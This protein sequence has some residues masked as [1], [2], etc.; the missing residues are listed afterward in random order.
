MASWWT[1]VDSP[2]VATDNGSEP[3]KYLQDAPGSEKPTEPETTPPESTNVKLEI[4]GC[5]ISTTKEGYRVIYS[6]EDSDSEVENFGLIY[7]L[8]V[9]DSDRVI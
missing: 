6:L 2:R 4:N 1:Q 5:Q 9:N 8:S 3:L 7:G